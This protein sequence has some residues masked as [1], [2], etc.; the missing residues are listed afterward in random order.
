MDTQAEYLILIAFPRQQWLHERASVLNFTYTAGFVAFASVQFQAQDF[1][2]SAIWWPS[3]LVHLHGPAV[4]A[5]VFHGA[6]FPLVYQPC[7]K[8]K[9]EEFKLSLNF[10]YSFLHQHAY[11]NHIL[12][13]QSYNK[14]YT[15][16]KSIFIL[17]ETE[18]NSN[19]W[20]TYT[21]CLAT[22]AFS[23]LD[24]LGV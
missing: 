18:G 6:F 5:L 20:C 10:T 2:S 21:V 4:P 17:T 3:L 7:L 13:T 12:A 16:V 19:L 14:E 9:K 1:T 22:L 24:V 11:Y 8:V 15:E 23:S